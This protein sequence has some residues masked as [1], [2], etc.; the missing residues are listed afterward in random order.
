MATFC[1]DAGAA[2][3][4]GGSEVDEMDVGK[5]DAG[6][7]GAAEPD[8]GEPAVGKPEVGKTDAGKSDAAAPDVGETDVGKAEVGNTGAGKPDGG[9]SEVG[10]TDVGRPEVGNTDAGKPGVGTGEPDAPK[11]DVVN[12][13]AGCGADAGLGVG[14]AQ[15]ISGSGLAFNGPVFGGLAFGEPRAARIPFSGAAGTACVPEVGSTFGGDGGSVLRPGANGAS[16]MPARLAC[17]IGWIAAA[18]GASHSMVASRV[19]SPSGGSCLSGGGAL[20]LVRAASA[21]CAASANARICA[22]L[23]TNSTVSSSKKSSA[24]LAPRGSQGCRGDSPQWGVGLALT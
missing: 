5:T 22:A 2:E 19:D 20:L 14:R 18:V 9:E 11:P 1:A 21:S 17:K 13:D 8:A 6:R 24:N 4:S 3:V 15:A 7:T 23:S 16:V 10:E 12:T